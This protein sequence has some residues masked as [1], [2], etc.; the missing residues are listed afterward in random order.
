MN[1]CDKCPAWLDIVMKDALFDE[2]V[3]WQQ[4]ERVSSSSVK[5]RQVES[6]KEDGQRGNC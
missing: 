4:W 1:K 6:G 5:T 2:V 3:Q